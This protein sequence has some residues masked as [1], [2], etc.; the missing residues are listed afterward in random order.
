M[1]TPVYLDYNATTPVAEAALRRMQPYL[2][3]RFGNPSSGGHAFGWMAEEAVEL[4]REE[5][6]ALLGVEERPAEA[7]TFTSG[8]TEALNLAIKGVARAYQAKG[9]HVVTCRTEHKAVLGACRALEARGGDVTYLP[10]EENGRVDPVRFAEALTG[11]TVLAAVMLA[12]NETGVLQP[13]EELAEIA[14]EA[15]VLFL[16]DATQAVGKIP[17]EAERAD[18][19]VA[20]AHKFYGPKGAGVL[21]RSRRRPRVRSEPLIHGGGQEGGLRGGTLNVPA[22]A[23]MGAAAELAQ[24]HRSEDAARLEAL[25]DRFEKH[26]KA[27]IPDVR[28]NGA[29]TE[30]LPQTANVTFPGVRAETLE[31]ELRDLAVST[32]SACST[33]SK[34]PSHVLKGM[35]LT[36]AEARATL[37]FSLGRPTTEEEVQFAA[38]R[39]TEAVGELR[40]APVAA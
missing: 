12:N 30:R 29:G 39:V 11:E 16:T 14:R 26:L 7:L 21:Y 31:S 34:A 24:E 35:G 32:G 13:I 25:R 4:A 19:L 18:L 2:R 15:G 28:I 8:A 36:D 1:Q 6:A 22:L 10:V 33:G 40:S 38:E 23:G 27:E 9:R 20:S 5:V 17:V 3:E 37:R